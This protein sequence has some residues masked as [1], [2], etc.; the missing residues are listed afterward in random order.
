MASFQTLYLAMP[1]P[2]KIPKKKEEAWKIV[3]NSFPQLR[4]EYV[5]FSDL[6]SWVRE[7][8]YC[9]N[10]LAGQQKEHLV[11]PCQPT[12]LSALSTES[13]GVLGH[14]LGSPAKVPDK[15][16]VWTLCL[17]RLARS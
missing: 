15:A 10:W 14:L 1:N 7:Y 16:D 8:W 9:A 17:A 12:L 3:I 4:A 5:A 11:T 2:E 6:F 13:L